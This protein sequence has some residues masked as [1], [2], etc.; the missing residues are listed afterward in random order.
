MKVILT[1]TVHGL[2]GRGD[3]VNVKNGYARNYL[4][5]KQLAKEATPGNLKV[6]E[7]QKIKWA[8]LE[9]AELAE[10]KS[11][12]ER[13]ENARVTIEKRVGDAG[14][15]YGSV[16]TAEIAE[17]LD[18]QGIEIDKRRIEMPEAIKTVGE[19]ELNVKVHREV[20]AKLMVEVVPTEESA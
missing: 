11:A 8:E 12:A 10:A 14:T 5:P 1:E 4:L 16:T 17:E 2:G 18:K 20:E 13:I 7:Q 3:V 9:K 19:H 15:L 6:V